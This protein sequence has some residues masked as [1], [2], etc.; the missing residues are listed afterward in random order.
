MDATA[1]LS[2]KSIV[3]DGWGTM[4]DTVFGKV[5]L[6]AMA[7]TVNFV[8]VDLAQFAFVYRNLIASC[9]LMSLRRP[10]RKPHEFGFLLVVVEQY[11]ADVTTRRG[12]VLR[13]I[14]LGRGA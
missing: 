3:F 9:T 2:G 4:M 10:A 5:S 6:S 13:G 8:P 14:I 12:S 7:E 1:L 11:N